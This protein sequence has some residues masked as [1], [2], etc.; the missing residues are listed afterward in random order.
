MDLLLY[1]TIV[2]YNSNS[3]ELAYGARCVNLETLRTQN[4]DTSF[5]DVIL[6]LLHKRRSEL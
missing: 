3:T 4:P 1:L 2:Q 5:S 6:P